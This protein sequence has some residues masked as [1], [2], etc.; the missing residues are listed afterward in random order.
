MV[1]HQSKQ[2]FHVYIT[3]WDDKRRP[4]ILLSQDKE[5]PGRNT[6]LVA[7]LSSN[8]T[9]KNP[10]TVPV[11]INGMRACIILDQLRT[12]DENRLFSYFG[13]ID[14]DTKQ[15]ILT[16]LI[17]YFDFPEGRDDNPFLRELEIRFERGV[18]LGL[19][20]IREY[21]FKEVHSPKPVDVIKN[22]ADEY[23]VAFLNSTGGRIVWAMDFLA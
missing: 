4:C 23:A 10:Y 20:E 9:R 17:R 8:I 14:E 19:E 13:T 6:V 12:V 5:Y 11:T 2:R 21:E 1:K 15:I 22:T 16:N 18:T 7:P 3:D